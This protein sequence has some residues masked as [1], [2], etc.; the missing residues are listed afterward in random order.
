MKRY[1]ISFIAV[2]WLSAVAVDGSWS[3]DPPRDFSPPRDEQQL[4]LA[5]HSRMEQ[6]PHI[7]VGP[8]DADLVG[9]DNRVL[10]AAVEYIAALGGGTVE[11][12][13]G[14]FVMRDS[15]H[16]RSHVTVRGVSGKTV[17]RKADGV[18]SSLALDGDFGEQQIT[19]EDVDGFEVGDGV[20]IWDNNA[21]GG[22][23]R[24]GVRG[25]VM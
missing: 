7:T 4:P 19:V 24:C 3:A 18:V 5:M 25:R 2:A 16:L 15:L 6:L 17:L 12:M 14:D 23:L 22:S 13:A 10:Q 20:A 8:Q 9:G 21:G 1:L 11:I